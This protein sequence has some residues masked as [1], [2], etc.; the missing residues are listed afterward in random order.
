M[1]LYYAGAGVQR[2]IKKF[3]PIARQASTKASAR[4]S[5]LRQSAKLRKMSGE[6]ECPSCQESLTDIQEQYDITDVVSA[7]AYLA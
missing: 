6:V 4:Y 3:N 1:H 7:K 5:E 2:R